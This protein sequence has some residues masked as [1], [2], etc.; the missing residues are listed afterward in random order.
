MKLFHKIKKALGIGAH[1]GYISGGWDSYR[2]S[3]LVEGGVWGQPYWQNHTQGWQKEVPVGEWRTVISAARK[4][5]WNCGVV[6][7]AID[8]KALLTC[9]GGA[10]RP[11][12]TGANKEWGK[13]AEAWLLDWMQI[14]DS[15]MLMSPPPRPS[16]LHRGIPADCRTRWTSGRRPIVGWM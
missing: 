8:Q 3:R 13:R 14:A 12:F 2:R 9:G 15:G 11:I 10:F 7:A 6:N 4:L 5:Y 16:R 1:S